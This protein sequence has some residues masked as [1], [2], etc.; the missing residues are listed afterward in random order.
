LVAEEIKKSGNK[1]VCIALREEA[2]L[3]LEEICDKIFWISI[4]RF[5]KIIDALKIENVESVILAGQVKHIKIYSAINMDLRA[6][7]VMGGLINKKAN[8]I[9]S[10][11]ANEF[12]KD[13]ICLVSSHIYLRYLFIQKK[14]LISG[15]KLSYAERKDVEFGYKIAKG[16]AGFDIGQTVVVKDRSV[17]AI[18]SVEGTDECIKRAYKLG[19]ANSI[20]VKV[21]KPNQ[22]FRFDV[23][24]IGSNTL[25]VL[26]DNKI[27]VMAIETGAT[28]VLDKN[29]V[30][31]KAKKMNI[32]MLAI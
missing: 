22:D 13:G 29:E 3:K 5:Q 32:T 7:K 2:D 26:R 25:D 16:I 14:G 4:G 1:V 24:V 19:G 8:T 15:E 27:R 9:L 12:E 21:A 11:I 10:M 28:L 18:E 30:I 23:P 20:V 31:E 17:L 6:I